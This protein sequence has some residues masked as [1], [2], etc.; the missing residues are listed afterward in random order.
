MQ[1]WP[2]KENAFAASFVAAR[3]RAAAAAPATG[4]AVHDAGRGV[5]ELQPHALLRRALGDAPADAARARESDHPNP[6]VLH[7][8]VTDLARGPDE[9]VEPA[10]RKTRFLLELRE[11]QSRERCLARRL[12]DDRT[13]RGERGCQ[14]VCDEVAREVEGRD[15]ADDPDRAA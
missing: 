5:A 1:L 6:L 7:E 10:G 3:A 14:L 2:A 12:E 15:R 9:D 8:H 13:A 4:V 11:E